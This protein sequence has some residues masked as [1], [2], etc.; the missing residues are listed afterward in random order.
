MHHIVVQCMAG[1]KRRCLPISLVA[2]SS[3]QTYPPT[4]QK[5]FPTTVFDAPPSS[6]N[7]VVT[8]SAVVTA[9]RSDPYN[10]DQRRQIDTVKYRSI[11][12]CDSLMRPDGRGR[13][14]RFTASSSLLR[15]WLEILHSRRWI[16]IHATPWSRLNIEWR[17]A[18]AHANVV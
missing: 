4:L 13:Q 17:G 2:P 14:G 3:K 18:V 5:F 8:I 9:T 10:D 12:A 15:A 16:H 11:L 1:D 6:Y 7:Q